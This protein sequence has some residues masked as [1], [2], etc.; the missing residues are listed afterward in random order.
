MPANL[1]TKLGQLVDVL[2]PD[3]TNTRIGV[4]NA[5]PTRTLDVTGT[6][7]A[8]G[9]STLGGTL[10][11]AAA[12]FSGAITAAG[13]GATLAATISMNANTTGEPAYFAAGGTDTN[14]GIDLNTKGT[15]SLRLNVNSA[16]AVTVANGGLVGIGMTP[17]NVL[18]I[19]QN[20]N[21]N[22]ITKLLN[23][24]AGA[25]AIAFFSAS[26]GTA[27]LS[28]AMFGTGYT[29]SGVARTNGAY[30]GCGGAGGITFNT[31]AAQPIYF[32]I[33]S[34]EKARI[35]T[36]GN[37]LVGTTTTGGW[38][39]VAKLEVV[40]GT[41]NQALSGYN[42]GSSG[43][44][45]VLRTDN[46]N[47]NLINFNRNGVAAGTFV[48]TGGGTPNIQWLANNQAYVIAGG[49]GGVTLASAA[50]A[51][52]AVSDETLKTDLAPI[53]SGA[54]KVGS[55]RA[56]TGRYKTDAESMSRS[57]LIAQD[58]QKVLP[59]AVSTDADGTL[60]L[61]YTEVIPLMVAAIQELTTR[62]ATLEN[63]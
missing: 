41:G 18:D 24:N 63:K 5:S 53:Q 12:N 46:D 54:E 16:V 57:F 17:V 32:G 28:L 61:R 35:D 30:I 56:V 44:A 38:T 47:S 34:V 27:S 52:A 29:S 3:T 23:S 19:T 14:V 48:S 58:V 59:E 21:G 39:T 6:F 62:L 20:Q 15:G 1:T 42:S 37:L 10:T 51:W 36:S 9:A 22:T 25:A 26:N 4:A 33:N 40:A 45:L 7:G 31:E 49:S 8:S 13:T 11:A 2:T 43:N 60:S 55:L 50:T